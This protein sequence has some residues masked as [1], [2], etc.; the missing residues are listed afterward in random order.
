MKKYTSLALGVCITGGLHAMQRHPR[1]QVFDEPIST[2]TGQNVHAHSSRAE[3]CCDNC[4]SISVPVLICGAGCAWLYTIMHL[5]GMAQDSGDAG[6][7]R[8]NWGE[9]AYRNY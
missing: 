6:D 2:N 4:C 5:R 9:E 3:E 7:V 8:S 1:P